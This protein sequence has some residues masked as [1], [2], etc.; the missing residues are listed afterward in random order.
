MSLFVV[1]EVLNALILS[2]GFALINRW[3]KQQPYG[4]L[5]RIVGSL[6]SAVTLVFLTLPAIWI[7]LLFP[8]VKMLLETGTF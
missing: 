5:P 8:A 2:I 7:V 1:L 3:R 4:P 6:L